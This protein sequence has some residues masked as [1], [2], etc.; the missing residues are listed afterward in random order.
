MTNAD[1]AGTLLRFGCQKHHDDQDVGAGSA[2]AV[3]RVGVDLMPATGMPPPPPEIPV[4]EVGHWFGLHR[5][6]SASGRCSKLLL[7]SYQAPAVRH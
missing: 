5:K 7:G 4:N 2:G 3:T 6:D 1:H